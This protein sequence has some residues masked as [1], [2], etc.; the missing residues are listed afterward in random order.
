MAYIKIV[1]IKDNSKTHFRKSLEYIT[2]KDKTR[3]GELIDSYCCIPQYAEVQFEQVRS[4]EIIKKGNNAAWHLYQS[5]AP[6]DNVTPE[7]ALEI[8]K[9][10][11]KRFYP[12]FQYVIATHIDKGHI[13]NHILINSVDFKTFHKLH[14]NK[15]TLAQLQAVSNDISLENSLSVIDKDGTFL[16][17]RAVR[18]AAFVEIEKHFNKAYGLAKKKQ[19]LPARRIFFK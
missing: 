8:G 5:F 19:S 10:L 11:M 17:R 15:K 14:S 6:E 3:D 7:H 16:Q 18:Q 9:E 1:P 13:H 2:R 12:N 4:K